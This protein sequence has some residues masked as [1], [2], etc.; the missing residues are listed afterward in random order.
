MSLSNY[1]SYYCVI[2][3]PLLSYIK[4]MA[5]DFFCEYKNKTDP[6]KTKYSKDYQP[7]V[8]VADI[9][10][11]GRSHRVF[12]HKTKRTH[13]LI[14]SLR[15]SYFLSGTVILKTYKSSFL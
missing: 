5:K 3:N 2:L 7:F 12:G 9:S 1:L 15:Y 11:L 14:L 13:H 8:K 10:S 4:E 6:I